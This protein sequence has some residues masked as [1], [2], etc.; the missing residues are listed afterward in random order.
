MNLE[1]YSKDRLWAILVE[2]VHASVMYPSHKAYI[3]ETVLRQKPE[4]TPLELASRFSMPLGEAIVIL[5]ELK[6]E[7]KSE[8]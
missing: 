3:R 2:T 6:A 1:E 4:V 8:T 5:E 7:N